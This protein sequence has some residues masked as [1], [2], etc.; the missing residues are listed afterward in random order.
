MG[1][2]TVGRRW[3]GV[4]LVVHGG[5][6]GVLRARPGV[7]LA[8]RRD[9]RHGRTGRLRAARLVSRDPARSRGV[10]ARASHRSRALL[11]REHR[12]QTDLSL[13]G[14]GCVAVDP[15]VGS[16]AL[17]LY[18]RG[19]KVRARTEPAGFLGLVE[20]LRSEERRVGT[21]CR[22]RWFTSVTHPG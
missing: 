21:E 11:Q 7:R 9:R 13:T 15:V 5:T 19:L 14:A 1:A 18:L 17:A 20:L 6:L 3:S 4:Q 8:P 12:E 10:A 16:V 2:A 22:S